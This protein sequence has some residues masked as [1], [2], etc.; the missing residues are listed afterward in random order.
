[1]TTHCYICIWKERWSTVFIVT[2]PQVLMNDESGS[3]CYVLGS[4][5]GSSRCNT[6]QK[7][8]FL[9]AL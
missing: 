5:S 4:D 3:Y 7:F 2:S 9:V 6:D 1:M 8:V